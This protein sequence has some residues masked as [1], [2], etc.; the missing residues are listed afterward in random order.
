MQQIIEVTGTQCAGKSWAIEAVKDNPKVAVFDI[1]DFYKKHKIIKEDNSFDWNL[2]R[3]KISLLP[4]EMNDFFIAAKNKI[5]IIEHTA[6]QKIKEILSSYQ[7]EVLE[8]IL[9]DNNTLALRATTRG[10]EAKQVIS[11]RETY[12]K[13]YKGP[14]QL[15][16]AP[17]QAKSFLE[18]RVNSNK[19]KINYIFGSA[20][21][22]ISK[23]AII[24]HICN[25]VGAWGAGFVIAI[26]RKWDKPEASYR[27]WYKSGYNWELGNVQFVKVENDIHIANMIAQNNISFNSGSAPIDYKAVRKSLIKLA[28]KATLL[29][30]TVHM[31][32]IG[33]GLAGGK[34]NEIEVIINETLIA[35]NIPVYVYTLEQDKSWR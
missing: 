24:C 11:F 35:R 7:T 33:C 12:S 19:S 13:K 16:L 2:W 17:E 30:A 21:E 6:N 5:I 14:K 3:E 4:A 28:T 32:R 18:N 31:P 15:L 1:M 20:L 34:W 10:L 9:P 25:N 8:L 29:N 27:K 26:S 23:P 22:P